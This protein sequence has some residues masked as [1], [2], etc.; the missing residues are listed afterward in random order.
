M[1]KVYDKD[2]GTLIRLNTGVDI[3]TASKCKII[4]KPPF[5]ST[6]DLAATII[7]KTKLQHTK[8]ANTLAKPG[9][10][11]LQAYVEFAGVGEYCGEIVQLTIYKSLVK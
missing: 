2:I 5:G 1:G 9:I 4:A 3:S 8:L 7:D 11:Q 10:W 6:I